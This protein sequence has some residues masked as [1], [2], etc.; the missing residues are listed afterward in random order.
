MNSKKILAATCLAAVTAFTANAQENGRDYE[1]YPYTFVSV[2][3][4][5]QITF[6]NNSF[7]KLLTPIGA[8]SVGHFFT[9]AVGARLNVQGWQNKAGYKVSGTDK[10]FDFNY[11]TTDLDLMFNL[12]NIFCPGKTH[13]F[14]AILV[15]GVGLAYAWDNDDQATLLSQ[16]GLTEPLA[17][18]D[19]RLVHNF[20]IGMQFEVNVAKHLGINLEVAANHLN[21]R[22]N[23]KTN[24]NPDWQ[25]T[26]MVGL[27]YK[28]GFK[29]RKQAPT[30][31]PPVREEPAPVVEE[32]V[33]EK[34][35]EPVVAPKKKEST[36]VEIF[37]NINSTEV[38]GAEA[39][40]VATLADWLKQHPDAK[41]TLTGYADAGTGTA[42]INRE[43][44][45]KRVAAVKDLLTSK[46]GID[47]GRIST[48]YK[49]DTVQPYANNDK[50][51]VVVGK[52]AE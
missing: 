3:G 4:G 52:A 43:L 2:Q 32:P 20:R 46:Y 42:K 1:P 48:D 18:D 26:G 6:T 45:E 49:G 36:P 47:G 12:S 23:S 38:T 17:W 34:K 13:A 41:C 19:D 28:F 37:F 44:S 14:N 9:P 11:F 8:V 33:V 15:G 25:L 31:P 24:G 35:E 10:T 51:R 39:A 7:D 40:K 27:T 29:K 30:P 22:F 5:G 16:Y 21:D 50:N